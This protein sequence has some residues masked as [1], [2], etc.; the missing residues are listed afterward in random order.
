MRQRPRRSA[1]V[2]RFLS[3][4]GIE[5]RRARSFPMASDVVRWRPLARQFPK[6]R[7]RCVDFLGAM[8]RLPFGLQARA[9]FEGVG[10]KPLGD[11]LVSVPAREIRGALAGPF[12]NGKVTTGINLTIARGYTGQTTEALAL[13]GEGDP[14]ERVA[15]VRLPCYVTASIGYRLGRTR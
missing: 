10:R 2:S 12:A 9:E 13:P 15:G 5:G 11:G 7:G 4:D 3:S 6:R 14:F 1:S 8:Q